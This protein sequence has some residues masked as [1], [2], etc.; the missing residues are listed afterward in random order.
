MNVNTYEY[1]NFVRDTWFGDDD[2][3]GAR[4]VAAFGLTGEAG[5]FAEKMKK[6]LR[7]DIPGPS[8]DEFIMELGDVLFYITKLADT[9][10]ITL[11][12]IIYVNERKL[13]SRIIRNVQR[14]SGDDR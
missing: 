14:G 4:L 7:G 12:D 11:A 9:F 5:E 1:D 13:K 2:P 3:Q 10:G 6:R 8:D